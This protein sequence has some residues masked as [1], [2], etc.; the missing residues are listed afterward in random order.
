[1]FQSGQTNLRGRPA[2]RLLPTRMVTARAA[3]LKP[4][5][6]RPLK[7][8]LTTVLTN[9]LLSKVGEAGGTPVVEFAALCQ[10]R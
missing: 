1:M 9:P 8:R 4:R 3:P 7:G 5:T 10:P 2:P 6:V